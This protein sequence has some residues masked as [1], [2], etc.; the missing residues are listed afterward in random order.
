MKLQYLKNYK[1]ILFYN[2]YQ[3]H[4]DAMINSCYMVNSF[5]V[6]NVE[7]KQTLNTV[8]YYAIIIA[9]NSSFSKFNLLLIIWNINYY[10][11]LNMIK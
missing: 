8:W 2:L 10:Y 7:Y 11:F 5:I 1:S 9:D 3:T 6:K 4:A